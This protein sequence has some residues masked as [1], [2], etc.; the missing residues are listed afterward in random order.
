M[1]GSARVLMDNWKDKDEKRHVSVFFISFSS[2][3]VSRGLFYVG[4]ESLLTVSPPRR[5]N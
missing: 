5:R 2:S 3:F 1:F 4:I